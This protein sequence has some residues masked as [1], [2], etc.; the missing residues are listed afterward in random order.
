MKLKTVHFLSTVKN[1]KAIFEFKMSAV[2]IATLAGAT[3]VSYYLVKKYGLTHDIAT[4]AKFAPAK[5]RTNRHIAKNETIIDVFEHTVDSMPPHHPAL[6]YQGSAMT[7]KD[8]DDASNQ[9][10]NWGLSIGLQPHDVVALY[11][12]NRPDF[13]AIWVGLAKIG[14]ITAFINTHISKES[15][16]HCLNT[17]GAQTIIFGSELKQEIAGIYTDLGAGKMKC[18]IHLEDGFDASS[19]PFAQNLNVLLGVASTRRPPRAIRASKVRLNDTALMI[20]TSGTTGMPKAACMIHSSILSRALS[21]IYAADATPQDRLYCALPLYHTAGGL[22]AVGMMMTSGLSVVL[23]RRFS[24]SSLWSD[25][26]LN[27]C[28]ILHYIGEFCRYLLTI[29]PK[30]NDRENHIRLAMGNGLRPDIWKTFQ[31]RY[32]IPTV[33][34]VGHPIVILRKLVINSSFM[35]QLKVQV[36]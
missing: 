17:S 13:V 10:A 6:F 24:A 3:G 32:G 11:M 19:T 27:K 12:E 33:I 36:D 9:V 35:A 23:A 28:T 20:Y 26:R 1:Y 34:E 16:L 21:F 25:I 29:P 14:V 18:F 4:I 5:L 31:D 22:V 30:A 2:K 15:L 8:L 7:F